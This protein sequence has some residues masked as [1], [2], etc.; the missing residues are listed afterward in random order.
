MFVL[1]TSLPSVVAFTARGRITSSDIRLVMVLVERALT[2]GEPVHVFADVT[3]PRG[4]F[5]AMKGQWARDFRMLGKLRR[6]GRVAIVSRNWWL[7]AVA[8]LESAVLPGISYR[9][10]RPR[11]RDRALAW[12]T[13]GAMPDPR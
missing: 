11:D 4:L 1:H 5:S 2:T 7:R 12:V 9:V 3:N 6:F 8:R 10:F 13:H